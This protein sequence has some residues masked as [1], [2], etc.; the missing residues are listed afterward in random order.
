MDITESSEL[1]ETDIPFLSHL[2]RT[3]LVGLDI[4]NVP[5]CFFWPMSWLLLYEDLGYKHGVRAVERAPGAYWEELT[6]SV[7]FVQKL[8][9]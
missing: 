6:A 4:E 9:F 1:F 7:V 3:T 8:L 5:C 2:T